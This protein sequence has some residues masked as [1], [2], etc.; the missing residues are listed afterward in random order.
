MKILI[1][2]DDICPTMDRK[3]WELADRILRRYHIKPLLGVI[4]DC[5]DPDLQIEP[6]FGG[7]WDWIRELQNRGYKVAMHGVHHLYITQDRGMVD[8][9]RH[10]EFVGVPYEEQVSMLRQG[11]KILEE[12]GIYTD[13]FF[14][15]AH[16]YDENTL[17]ALS[18]VGFRYISDGKSEKPYMQ[19]GI[20]CLPCISGGVPRLLRQGGYYTA[21]FHAHEWVRPEKASG[22][23]ALKKICEKYNNSIVSFDEYAAQPLGNYTMEK[24]SERFT[25]TYFRYIRPKLSAIKKCI[26]KRR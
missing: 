5:T 2:F 14:A 4:P 22:Y 24:M 3:Q 17:R 21:V 11:K 8:N 10:S 23:N 13:V 12:H 25:V 19:H 9:V 16:S 26:S 1:R 15:P 6:P 7:F 18:C 20:K